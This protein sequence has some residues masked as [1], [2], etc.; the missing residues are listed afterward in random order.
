MKWDATRK[1]AAKSSCE[2]IQTGQYSHHV[3]SPQSLTLDQYVNLLVDIKNKMKEGCCRWP[4]KASKNSFP[5]EGDPDSGNEGTDGGSE[6]LSPIDGLSKHLASTTIAAINTLI[7]DDNILPRVKDEELTMVKIQ[8]G[9][10]SL[11]IRE[12]HERTTA[13]RDEL[14]AFQWCVEFVIR[15]L[16]WKI[17]ALSDD[18]DVE[19]DYLEVM[20]EVMDYQRHFIWLGDQLSGLLKSVC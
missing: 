15:C 20:E 4:P 6:R 12:I 13:T 10:C 3:L 17:Q 8:M 14:L 2:L 16:Y 5:D 1:I 7:S 19:D 18:E 9:R 11:L